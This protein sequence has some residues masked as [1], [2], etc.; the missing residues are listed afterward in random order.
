MTAFDWVAQA[1]H[2]NPKPEHEARQYVFLQD[3]VATAGD[4]YR[5]HRTAIQSPDGIW[6][7]D[8]T[9]AI[10]AQTR[11]L[12]ENG[13]FDLSDAKIVELKADMICDKVV[14]KET[15]SM[16]RLAKNMFVRVE[17]VNQAVGDASGASVWYAVIEGH[18]RVG[19]FSE[20]G[21]F[22]VAGVYS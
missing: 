13:F 7:P 16:Y 11:P 5:V 3:G 21:D 22:V 12:Y 19:G 15:L 18:L 8:G 17:W 14:G 10:G 9:V 20:F 6:K 2:T 1:C 4:G